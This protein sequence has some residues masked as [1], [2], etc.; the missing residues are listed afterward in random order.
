MDTVIVTRHAPLVAL[1]IERGLATEDTPVI[2]HATIQDVL[3]KRVI[4]VLPLHL[5]C[6][7]DRVVEVVISLRPDERSAYA[8]GDIAIERLREIAGVAVEYS[9]CKVNHIPPSLLES[10]ETA[11]SLAHGR[12]R[13]SLDHHLLDQHANPASP[14][15]DEAMASKLRVSLDA[16]KRGGD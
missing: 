11:R 10:M 14:L 12:A 4:G 5:A 15:Y 7:A 2:A 3:G 13:E 16:A 8:A 6:W 9:V 1:L